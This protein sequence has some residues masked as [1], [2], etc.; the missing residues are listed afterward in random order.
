MI[1]FTTSPLCDGPPYVVKYTSIYVVDGYSFGTQHTVL[2][3]RDEAVM[4]VGVARLIDALRALV[5][6][7]SE[8]PRQ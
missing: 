4:E 2:P 1:L 5:R 7:H 8:G 3:T 6:V